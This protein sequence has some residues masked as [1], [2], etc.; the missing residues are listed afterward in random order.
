M[1]PGGPQRFTSRSLPHTPSPCTLM[2]GS[3]DVR[4]AILTACSNP[5]AP[6]W[7]SPPSNPAP[8]AS[9]ATAVDA[10]TSPSGT[11]NNAVKPGAAAAAAVTLAVSATN[12][13]NNA[14]KAAAASN[15]TASGPASKASKAAAAGNSDKPMPAGNASNA[16]SEV[17]AVASRDAVLGACA[18]TSGLL[19]LSGIAARQALHWAAQSGFPL[20]DATELLPLDATPEHLL[21]ALALAGGVTAARVA[22]VTVWPDFA[23]A[24]DVSNRQV[25]TNLETAD[26]PFVCCF[27]GLG[28]EW[29]FRGALL[30]A[31]GMDWKGVAVAGVVFGILHINGG[32]NAAFA[33][34]ASMVGIV[35]GASAVASGDLIVP[36]AAHA[37]ANL[38]SAVLWKSKNPSAAK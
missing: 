6:T 10:S 16:S 27:P 13:N 24:T 2:E 25:L 8:A 37:L 31:I 19:L 5:T 20:G 17:A 29:I 21:L 1:R 36:V 12:A 30:P 18:V 4:S 32:R 23:T 26:L 15:A 28:E 9:P 7:A 33:A 11:R 3:V 22:L 14:S 35:Y 34:W 38:M